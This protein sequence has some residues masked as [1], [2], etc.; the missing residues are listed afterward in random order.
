MLKVMRMRIILM[1][2]TPTCRANVDP[3]RQ[4][5]IQD[6]TNTNLINLRRTI[7]LTIMSSVDYEE[8]CHKLMK[9]NLQEGQEVPP[10]RPSPDARWS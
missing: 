3:A 4:M 10:P 7:Y 9:I 8:C 2:Y 1:V 5:E 6:E